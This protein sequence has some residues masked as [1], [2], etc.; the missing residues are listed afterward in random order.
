LAATAILTNGADGA[1]AS[2][3]VSAAG[4]AAV[5]GARHRAKGNRAEREIVEWHKELGIFAERVPLS[6]A[7][8]YQNAGHDVD[9][10][11]FGTDGMPF[12]AEVKARNN[13]QGWKLAEKWLGKSHQL[14]L[15]RDHARPL[16]VLSPEAYEELA[17]RA[18]GK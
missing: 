2:A 7:A 8:H 9:V 1:P 18:N 15:R 4:C 12:K 6:G 16:V 11:I 17:R 13:G 3:E 14:F 5:A 10:Y